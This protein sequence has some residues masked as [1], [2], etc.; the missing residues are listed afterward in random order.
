MKALDDLVSVSRR[1][2]ADPDWVLAG[3]GNTSYKDASTLW[4]KASGTQL[5][6]IDQGGFCAID[7]GRLAAIW[8]KAYP[9]DAD[10]REAAVLADLMAA[11]KEGDSKRPS[12]ETLLHGL[13]PQS[14]VLHTHPGLVNG[15]TCGREGEAAFRRLFSDLAIW[16][17]FVEPGYL[18]AK[19][20]REEAEA[21]R[22][23]SAGF[24]SLMFMQNHGLLVAGDSVAELDRLSALVVSRL[25]AELSRKPD[26]RAKTV[27]AAALVKA[28]A[29]LAS[30][31]GPD[32]A[33]LFRCDTE[34][35]ARSASAAAFGP[36]SAPFSPDHIVYAGHEFLRTGLDSISPAW[37]DCLK[38]NGQP[39]R[40]VVVEGLGAFA[41][42]SGQA[43]RSTAEK[44]MLLFV[45]ACGVAAYAESF[46]GALHM[47]PAMVQFIRSWEVEKYRASIAQGGTA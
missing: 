34:I 33:I 31:A 19:A 9:R 45:D 3:G 2:G 38:R 4:I 24:P 12:V 39:P 22:S 40:I 1:Y 47:S 23:R 44:A 20:V 15:L 30:L 14:F 46:G 36:L 11:R 29:A 32:P 42:A 37:R 28:T 21:F 25:E 13:F 7:R 5:S 43:A 27:D 26:R 35:L 17:P 10:A 41:V 6:T 18:L 16:V 8:E